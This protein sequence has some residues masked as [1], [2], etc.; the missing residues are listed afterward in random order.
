LNQGYI[1][2][3]EVNPFPASANLPDL[4]VQSFTHSP[5]SP[6]TADLITFTAVVKN[7]GAVTAPPSTLLFGIGGETPVIVPETVVA[8]PALA[9]GATFTKIRQATLTAQGYI[10][11]AT[12]DYFQVV[13]ETNE[14]NNTTTDAY[15]VSQVGGAQLVRW[16]LRNV[17][18]DDGGTA[19][20]YFVVRADQSG[21]FTIADWSIS[22]TGG[23]NTNVP[24]TTYSPATGVARGGLQSRDVEFSL[25][26]VFGNGVRTLLLEPALASSNLLNPAATIQ[27]VPASVPCNTLFT[28]CAPPGTF[29]I[30]CEALSIDGV[31]GASGSLSR[32]IVA[33]GEIYSGTAG[34]GTP[35]LLSDTRP[36]SSLGPA[37]QS[38]ASLVEAS[39]AR[40]VI[41]GGPGLP[42]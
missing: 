21:N 22:V 3:Y 38:A 29:L 5:L 8:V 33:G 34:I 10:N 7:I 41:I 12:A 4:I 37:A 17:T 23:S 11:T 19:N 30:C 40:A 35:D 24:P 14:N 6:T 26:P 31:V 2:E 1:V 18:F 25:G 42:N 15:T 16:N 20:G 13:P 27:I 39:F 32:G 28:N 36:G 9:P